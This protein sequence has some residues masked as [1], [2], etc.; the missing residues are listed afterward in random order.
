AVVKPLTE[1]GTKGVSIVNT[2][3]QLVAAIELLRYTYGGDYV[4]QEYVPGG[5]GSI[6]MVTLLYDHGAKLVGAVAMHSTAPFM[7]WGGSGNAG[8]IVDEPEAI[9]LSERVIELAGGWAGPVCVE[10]KQHA[11]NNRFFVMEA[12]CRLNGYSYLTTLNGMNFPRAIVD[13]LL[14][15][16]TDRLVRYKRAGSRNFV[17]GFRAKL[18]VRWGSETLGHGS[19]ASAPFA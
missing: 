3:D 14:H 10:F 16:R 9:R 18:V 17:L 2:R 19:Y 12:N 8:L 5:I 13:L 1:G 7:T 11:D 6:H 4:L 15:G